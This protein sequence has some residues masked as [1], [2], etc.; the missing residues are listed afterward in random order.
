MTVPAW[1]IET[2]ARIAVVSLSPTG[3]P[4]AMTM[5]EGTSLRAGKRRI[6]CE[7]AAVSGHV[8]GHPDGLATTP[9]REANARILTDIPAKHLR[10][11]QRL[12]VDHGGHGH[13]TYTVTEVKAVG[14]DRSQLTLDRPCRER[15]GQLARM[16]DQGRVLVPDTG[17][18]PPSPGT[19]ICRRFAGMWI[20]TAGQWYRL[21]GDITDAYRLEAP[22]GGTKAVPGQPYVVTRLGPG[23]TIRIP[24]VVHLRSPDPE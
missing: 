10:V 6:S 8:L 24:S 12:Y 21:R 1:Q 11:G 23:D 16:T 5:V 20:R 9:F 17:L 7:Q 2:D 3:H 13:S 4:L 15:I 22:V 18:P 14:P 19:D